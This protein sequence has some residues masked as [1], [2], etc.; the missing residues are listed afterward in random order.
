[1]HDEPELVEA[2]Q[3][4]GGIGYV[5]KARLSSDLTIAFAEA[6]EGRRYVPRL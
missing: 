4:A 1:M 2:A 5:L 3:A 6:L